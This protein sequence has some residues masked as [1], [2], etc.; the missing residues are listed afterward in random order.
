LW[1]IDLSDLEEFLP[2]ESEFSLNPE[3]SEVKTSGPK[4]PPIS[5]HSSLV[6]QH[7]MFLFGG[8]TRDAEN[9]N[10][11]SLDLVK[12]QW[13]IVKSKALHGD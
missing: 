11:Y 7:K 10:M 13:A 4:P 9:L 5:H 2:G 3:W 8:S 6:Y 1:N 12:D